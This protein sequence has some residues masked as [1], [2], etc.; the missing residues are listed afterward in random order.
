[1]ASSYMLPAAKR[2][3]LIFA[4]SSSHTLNTQHYYIVFHHAII[5]H[6]NNTFSTIDCV[7]L[8]IFQ[9]TC[10]FFLPQS[11]IPNETCS[12]ISGE[13]ATSASL[14]R[15][16]RTATVASAS[17]NSRSTLVPLDF[18]FFDLLHSSSTPCAQTQLAN[19]SF[20]LLFSSTSQDRRVKTNR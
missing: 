12:E 3:G 8:R 6:P 7:L 14:S 10:F 18:F 19:H 9:I 20:L 5:V 4:S 15:I 17:R 16:V 2:N 13:S 1:M 11:Q